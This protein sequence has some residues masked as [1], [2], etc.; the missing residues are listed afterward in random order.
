MSLRQFVLRAAEERWAASAFMLAL[1]V[2]LLCA[3]G[4][5]LLALGGKP[6]VIALFLAGGASAT[7]GAVVLVTFR[8]A[9]KRW[10]K[11]RRR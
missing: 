7:G 1:G 9:R 6:A 5:L 11:S 2:I 8:I 3:G 10:S 4:I